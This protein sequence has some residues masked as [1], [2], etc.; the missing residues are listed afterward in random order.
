MEILHAA[1]RNRNPRAL[2]MFRDPSFAAQLKD[3]HVGAFTWQDSLA[4]VALPKLKQRI[5]GAFP[6]NQVGEYTCQVSGYD[7]STGVE[8]VVL[9]GLE[10]EFSERV[11]SVSV[12]PI[13]TCVSSFLRP[14]PCSVTF[15]GPDCPH[16][17]PHHPEPPFFLDSQHRS[18]CP[19]EL[20][21]DLLR[22]VVAPLLSLHIAPL[23]CT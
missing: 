1:Y 10:G 2:F 18:L 12:T 8:K 19:L 20:N 6:P 9:D 11:Y 21:P 15:C 17:P 16:S 22:V 13:R 3:N 5:K 4:K 23:T 7:E 14:F